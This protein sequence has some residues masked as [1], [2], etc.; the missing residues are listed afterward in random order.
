MLIYFHTAF[1]FL[2]V[3]PEKKRGREITF[4]FGK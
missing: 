4:F 3:L 1:R 2:F